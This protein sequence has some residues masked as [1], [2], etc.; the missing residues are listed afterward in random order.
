[1]YHT[2]CSGG[3]HSRKCLSNRKQY[4]LVLDWNYPKKYFDTRTVQPCAKKKFTLFLL[5]KRKVQ[6]R[7]S[8]LRISIYGSKSKRGTGTSGQNLKLKIIL[9][10]NFSKHNSI[11]Y[12]KCL[13]LTIT[14]KAV[15]HKNVKRI[16]LMFLMDNLC[17]WNQSS[18]IIQV[19][20]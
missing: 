19:T 15:V 14:A 8:E 2:A 13:K 9:S 16:D 3:G 1:M 10:L 12:T 6:F 11:T 18:S 5:K 4:Y 17:C 7:N 20:A